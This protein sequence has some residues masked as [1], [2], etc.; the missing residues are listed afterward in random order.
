MLACVH[1]AFLTGSSGCEHDISPLPGIGI[2]TVVFP[3]VLVYTLPGYVWVPLL[4]LV[5]FMLAHFVSSRILHLSAACVWQFPRTNRHARLVVGAAE[6]ALSSGWRW[7]TIIRIGVI[8]LRSTGPSTE[9]VSLL[10]QKE[11]DSVCT[12]SR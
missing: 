1:N 8:S 10:R 11:G 3:T 2:S 12:T 7:P 6:R 5:M 9:G 4:S